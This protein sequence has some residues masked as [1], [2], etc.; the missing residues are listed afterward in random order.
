MKKKCQFA[1][2]KVDYLGHIISKEGVAVDPSKVAS[3]TQW[4]VP[5]N[6]KGVRGFLGL[7]GYYKKFIRDYG[8]SKSMCEA[9][10][11]ALLCLRF[12]KRKKRKKM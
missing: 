2:T 11:S 6:V 1:Q 10:Q 9:K 5:K 8:T 4:P 12:E 7:T 3:V